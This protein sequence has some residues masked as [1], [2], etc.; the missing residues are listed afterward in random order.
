MIHR[1]LAVLVALAFL[2]SAISTTAA[3]AGKAADE[4]KALVA[5]IQEKDRKS[6]V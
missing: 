5:T 4:L 2:L 1:I 3:E 6:V